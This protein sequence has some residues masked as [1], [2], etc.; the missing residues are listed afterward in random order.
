MTTDEILMTR[1]LELALLGK[2]Y[3]APNPMVG[4][5]IVTDGIVIGEGHHHEYGQAHAEVNAIRN[6]P[7]EILE[8][9]TLYVN[10]EPCSHY[11]KTPPCADLIIKKKI[12]KV[13]IGTPDPYHEV[14]GRGI[15]KLRNSGIEVIT[16]VSEEACRE[17]NKRF[18]TFIEKKRPYII[19]KY[20]Q[21]A[22]GFMG[23]L[24]QESGKGKQIS[25]VLSQRLTHRWRSEET[26][27]LVGTNTAISDN[28]QLN[29]RLHSGKNPLRILIDRRLKVPASFHVYDGSIPTLIVT[30]KK[31][32]MNPNVS[33][34]PFDFGPTFIEDLLQKL[35]TQRIQSVLVEGGAHTLQTFIDSGLWDEARVFTAPF[36]WEQGIKAPKIPGGIHPS[37]QE[38][39]GSDTLTT[40]KNTAHS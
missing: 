24:P 26:S 14:A 28:P 40:Y 5:V 37:R 15:N 38:P 16:G 35:Y 11:G 9:S 30:E 34:L 3:V 8:R 1:C 13:V 2:G 32:A 21:T 17:L 10:L 7:E 4:C 18:F 6:I 36:S 31:E 25:N 27:I 39:M 23:R 22:D 29:V 33:F 20:A 12:K 19:L